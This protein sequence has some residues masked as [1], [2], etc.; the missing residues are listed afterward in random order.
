MRTA[1]AIFVLLAVSLPLAGCIDGQAELASQAQQHF[2]P[3]VTTRAQAIAT[4]GPPSSVY[5]AASGEK[6]LSWA[7][8][9]G[10]FDPGETKALAIL[11]GPDDVM[12]RIVAQPT[13]AP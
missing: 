9:G 5:I 13:P 3:G 11:F 2:S 7:R 12:I 8:D 6:T 4:L 1:V 10:L